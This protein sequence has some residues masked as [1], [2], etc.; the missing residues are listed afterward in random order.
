MNVPLH[1]LEVQVDQAQRVPSTRAQHSHG[2]LV[3]SPSTP[4]GDKKRKPSS[5]AYS[6]GVHFNSPLSQGSSGAGPSTSSSVTMVGSPYALPSHSDFSA[7]N[8]GGP[9]NAS[10]S[11]F[12]SIL[13]PPPAKKART[14][15][16]PNAP[17]VAPPN[18]PSQ[19]PAR[20]SKKNAGKKSKDTAPPAKM[21]STESM[22]AK[23]E[24]RSTNAATKVVQKHRGRANSASS[25]H[26]RSS[27]SGD[28]TE[29]VNDT[30]IKAAATLTEIFFSHLGGTGV[31]SPRS[32]FSTV[33]S[34]THGATRSSALPL[35]QSSS[36]SS[37]SG[38]RNAH[39]RTPSNASVSTASLGGN[40]HESVT[41]NTSRRSMTPA[42][43]PRAVTRAIPGS[44][45][46]QQLHAS[47]N[48]AADLMLLLANS[49][50]PA[51]PGPAA[52]SERDATRSALTGRVLFPNASSGSLMGGSLGGELGEARD[53]HP[54][55]LN[56][57][58]EH[59]RNSSR[60]FSPPEHS[61]GF[62]SVITPPTPVDP[63]AQLPSSGLL[64]APPS[65]TRS[66]SGNSASGMKR[67]SGSRSHTPT[68]AGP[69]TPFD[70]SDYIH[71]SPAALSTPNGLVFAHAQMGLSTVP[72][73]P[74]RL[75]GVNAVGVSSPLRKSVEAGSSASGSAIGL[76]VG[77]RRLF[78][79]EPGGEDMVRTGA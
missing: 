7:N 79:D 58:K 52:R 60:S 46:S 49:P 41:S 61:G 8:Y 78:G 70:M 45:N 75:R 6:T 76:G 32:S 23:K 29:P 9:A 54:P 19:P 68:N 31:A 1:K 71:D 26:T 62:E 42:T 40:E 65:P 34:G 16:N 43:T 74:R 36:T 63:P 44:A 53:K 67:T 11:L 12:S 30:D 20:T 55:G 64:P 17:L 10:H 72:G 57:T 39:A 77:G 21:K 38:A 56:S 66:N 22:K 2:S 50:S 14:I 5:S 51:R 25:I 48:E 33:S 4:S 27:L 13:A 28:A 69:E 35:S 18:P 59:A 3:A 37:T 15:I 24:G 47:D 73:T